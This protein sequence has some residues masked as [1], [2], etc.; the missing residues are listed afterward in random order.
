MEI[1][2][3]V[4]S[5]M[6]NRSGR[7]MMP[8]IGHQLSHRG[9]FQTIKSLVCALAVGSSMTEQTINSTLLTFIE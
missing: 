7:M 4:G 6:L 9:V 3:P 8:H 5:T 1:P 2:K